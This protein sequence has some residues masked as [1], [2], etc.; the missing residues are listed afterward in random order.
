MIRISYYIFK[1][2][3]ISSVTSLMECNT[4][5][6]KPDVLVLWINA[7]RRSLSW[8]EVKHYHDGVAYVSLERTRDLNSILNRPAGNPC[9]L[10]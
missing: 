8:D 5:S 6:Q 1:E 7:S 3:N 9:A 2:E 10:S 4:D